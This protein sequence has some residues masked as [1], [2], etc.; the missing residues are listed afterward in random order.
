LYKTEFCRRLPPISLQ[1]DHLP[2]YENSL[3]GDPRGYACGKSSHLLPEPVQP[4]A[5]P[6]YSR[7]DRSIDFLSLMFRRAQPG[8]SVGSI[9]LEVQWSVRHCMPKR[10]ALEPVPLLQVL[11]L[12]M[13]SSCLFFLFFS[14]CLFCCV[15]RNAARELV[16]FLWG[17]VGVVRDGFVVPPPT[18]NTRVDV[19]PASRARSSL[20]SATP[21]CS[22]HMLYARL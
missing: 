22:W 17:S 21:G 3:C 11:P 5:L 20:R 4:V 18:A 12:G 2:T 10:C 15:D 13:Y 9:G 14:V 6:V 7:M 19:C 1:S 16:V 8:V